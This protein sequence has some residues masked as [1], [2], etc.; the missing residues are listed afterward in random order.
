MCICSHMVSIITVQS[1]P[2]QGDQESS[3]SG[4]GDTGNNDTSTEETNSESC[5]TRGNQCQR[6]GSQLPSE[7]IPIR[8]Y[9]MTGQRD[10][11]QVQCCRQPSNQSNCTVSCNEGFTG[12]NVT[13]LCNTT[14]NNCVPV[15]G[16]EIMCERGLFLPDVS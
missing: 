6:Q 9:L 11:V 7:C 2:S 12:D 5:V 8:R 15:G 3:G 13:Y 4:L 1:T 16:Q 14:D 10:D